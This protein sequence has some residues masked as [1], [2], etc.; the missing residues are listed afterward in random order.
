MSQF[1]HEGVMLYVHQ[2]GKIAYSDGSEQAPPVQLPYAETFYVVVFVKLLANGSF[3]WLWWLFVQFGRF[4]ECSR[5][6][7]L[8]VPIEE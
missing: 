2:R 6:D 7:L 4:L 8:S 5:N 1:W 3:T